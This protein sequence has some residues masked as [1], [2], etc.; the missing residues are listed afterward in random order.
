MI[1]YGSEN[2][3]FTPETDQIIFSLSTQQKSYNKISQI[4]LKQIIF[5]NFNQANGFITIFL[6]MYFIYF[7]K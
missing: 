5:M 1:D 4:K 2:I 6:I 7:L 3:V